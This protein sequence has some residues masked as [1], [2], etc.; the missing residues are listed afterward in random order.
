MSS[1]SN[2]K[3]NFINS[4]LEI[5]CA[6]G[7]SSKTGVALVAVMLPRQS[8]FSKLNMGLIGSLFMKSLKYTL[9]SFLLLFNLGYL[10]AQENADS[11]AFEV[12][13]KRVNNLLEARQQ[14]F[15]AY[16]TSLTQKTGLF[17]LFKS[18]D[19]MQKSI[20]ILKD[21]VITD[22]NIFLET[23][24]L[25]KIKDFEKNKFRQMATEYDKQISSYIGTINKLQLENERLRAQLDKSAGNGLS[26]NIWLYMA[27]LVI[28]ALALLLYRSRTRKSLPIPK[29]TD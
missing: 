11:S 4:F 3:I 26:G 22:N 10:I 23:Q 17:G 28:M 18:K 9:L 6:H 19:D 12:Q 15:G 14:K 7:S 1:V 13:R 25:L 27:L 21:V 5:I 20:D 24:Q 29:N 16:D 2:L 8:N